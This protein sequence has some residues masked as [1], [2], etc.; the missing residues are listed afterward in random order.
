LSPVAARMPRVVREFEILRVSATLF[1]KD[2]TQNAETARKEV[3][4]WA[5]NRSGGR[6]PAE[7]WQF[8]NFE[9][10]SG[11]RNSVGVRL[12]NEH[13]D[14]WAI[15]ADD[16]DKNVAGRTWTTE[17][18]VGLM[19]GQ[20]P[21]FSARLLASTHEVELDIEP[22]TPGLVQQVAESCALSRGPQQISPEPWL[23]ETEKD[24]LQLVEILIDPYRKLPIFVLTVPEGSSD[25]NKPLIDAEAL[26]RAT[27]GNGFVVILPAAHSWVLTDHFGKQRS[28]FGGGARTYLP[29]FAPDSNPYAHRLVIG[30]HLSTADGAAQCMRWMRSLAATE[31]VRRILLGRDV[32]AFAAIRNA[33]LQIR[34]QQLMKEGASESEQ[35]VAANARIEALEKEVSDQKASLEYFDSE[36]KRAEERAETAEEQSRASAFRVQ[37][38]IEQI[39][40]AG[41]SVDSNI[42]LPK[43]WQEFGNWADVNLA[44]RVVLAP[45]ARRQVRSPEF[46]DVAVA[47]RCLLWLATACRE[48][49]MKGGEGSLREEIVEDGI[50]NAHCGADQFDLDWQGQRQTADWHIK[51]G[52]NTRD[53]KRCLRIYY[54]WHEPTQQIVVAEMPAHRRTA[55]T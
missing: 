2:S 30:D 31:S 54:F 20:A 40:A 13:S 46:A 28:V 15:R 11:G 6:L 37:Q 53:P 21:R 24:A 25:P 8:E 3:L 16:P 22:H 39:K 12:Q 23:I 14:I 41:S 33:S 10:F 44:G 35:L 34:Q 4:R 50:R 47:A 55:A 45:Q 26:A 51:N 17:V 43:S 42:E 52:G 29:G 36:H 27:L 18:T 49:R 9:Y 32:L 7:A 38:L 19:V 5:Q 48:R 1:G